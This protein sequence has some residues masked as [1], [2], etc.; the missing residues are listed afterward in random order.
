MKETVTVRYAGLQS[1]GG[2]VP[3][4][5]LY[6]V[7]AGPAELLNSTRTIESLE[8]DGYEVREN[9]TSPELEDLMDLVAREFQ[10]TQAQ[11]LAAGRQGSATT[12]ARH[13]AWLVATEELRA[14]RVELAELFHKDHSAVSY[15]IR[16]ARELAE[17]YP[18]SLFTA[19]LARVRAGLHHSPVTPRPS[20]EALCA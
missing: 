11:M 6:N 4:R 1:G 8:Q 13:A 14:T 17:I 16:R 7:I 12:D 9:R 10:I 2:F 15:G 3:S 18:N 19:R 20:T 5:A